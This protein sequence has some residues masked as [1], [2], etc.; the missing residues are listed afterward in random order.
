MFKCGD[1]STL[2]GADAGDKI[3]IGIVPPSGKTYCEYENKL[4]DNSKVTDLKKDSE[5][6][7]TIKY[8]FTM[9]DSPVTINNVIFDPN[10]GYSVNCN[11]NNPHI[12]I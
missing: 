11:S 12:Q 5:A 10:N 9:P 8:S 1:G 3:E 6:N 2:P 7:G 4:I